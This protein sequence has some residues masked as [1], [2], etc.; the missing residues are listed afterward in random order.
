[1]IGNSRIG[2]W[3]NKK[4]RN[5]SRFTLE[6]KM[7]FWYCLI[8]FFCGAGLVCIYDKWWYK[9]FSKGGDHLTGCLA[10]NNRYGVDVPYFIKELAALS[11]SLSDRTPDELNRYLLRLAEVAKPLKSTDT[12]MLK[13]LERLSFMSKRCSSSSEMASIAHDI[14]CEFEQLQQ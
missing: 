13:L 12:A 2:H 3:K 11:R 1:M 6:E 14:A 9:H 8:S 4:W 5:P 10:V 7:I